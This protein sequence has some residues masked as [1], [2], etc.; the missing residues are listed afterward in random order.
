MDVDAGFDARA[1]DHRLETKELDD[2]GA[3]GMHDLRHYRAD[4]HILHITPRIPADLQELRDHHR[5]F[6]R[7]VQGL[8]GDAV[9]ADDAL[10]LQKAD[11]DVGVSDI[12]GHQHGSVLPWF[13]CR[14]AV[15]HVALCTTESV[16]LFRSTVAI[17][18]WRFRRLR[19]ARQDGAATGGPDRFCPFSATFRHSAVAAPDRLRYRRGRG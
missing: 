9:G 13:G 16:R 6:V 2:R 10:A 5:I 1:H 7:R 12:Y 15:R 19:V 8:G 18:R 3:E 17:V 14:A 11:D 4:D